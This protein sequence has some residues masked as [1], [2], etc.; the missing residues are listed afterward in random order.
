MAATLRRLVAFVVEEDLHLLFA[1]TL[2]SIT[3]PDGATG[4]LGPA[5]RDAL[6]IFEDL[7]L[8]GN[9]HFRSTRKS[10]TST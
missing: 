5:T 2:G 7:Y 8:L 3:L 6:A 1:N 4:S 9:G 10:N